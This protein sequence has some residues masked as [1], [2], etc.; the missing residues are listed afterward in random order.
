MADVGIGVLLRDVED[1]L[2]T[3]VEEVELCEFCIVDSF[4]WLHGG[5]MK[6]LEVV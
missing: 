3:C 4:S 6:W 5:D 2:F 1:D